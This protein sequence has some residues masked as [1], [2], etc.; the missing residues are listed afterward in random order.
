MDNVDFKNFFNVYLFLYIMLILEVN[1]RINLE[2][3]IFYFSI[4]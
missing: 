1:K 4:L 3:V 2:N